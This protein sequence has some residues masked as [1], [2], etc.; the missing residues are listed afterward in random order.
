MSYDYLDKLLARIDSGEADLILYR[1]YKLRKVDKEG[2]DR[3][4][5]KVVLVK[6]DADSKIFRI[7]GGVHH[8]AFNKLKRMRLLKKCQFGKYDLFDCYE[9]VGARRYNAIMSNGDCF[10]VD[11]I[12]ASASRVDVNAICEKY[13]YKLEFVNSIRAFKLVPLDRRAPQLKNPF[14]DNVYT[15]RDLDWVRWKIAIID[16]LTKEG[17][18]NE[19]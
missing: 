6:F 17:V 5:S 9:L 8:K 1:K 10:D 16:K 7:V 15:L 4:L 13:G 2:R 18:L 3:L 12:S 14:I 11:D 19:R